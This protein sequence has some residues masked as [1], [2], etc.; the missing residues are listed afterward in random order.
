MPGTKPA[1]VAAS[2]L[3]MLSVATALACGDPL[4]PD[5]VAGTYVLERV[6]ADDLPTVLFANEYVR[7]RVLADTVH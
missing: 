4:A 2:V 1:R 3:A 5:E 7:I 6:G